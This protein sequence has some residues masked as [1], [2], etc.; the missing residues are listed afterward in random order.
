MKKNRI[1]EPEKCQ[2]SVPQDQTNLLSL[3]VTVLK[4][5]GGTNRLENYLRGH[6]WK[7][8]KEIMTAMNHLVLESM[9][10]PLDHKDY[11]SL[12]RA[13]RPCGEN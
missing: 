1:I 4:L 10:K 5:T 13:K 12:S 8:Y 6:F 7:L 11:F 3:S 9:Q 2:S